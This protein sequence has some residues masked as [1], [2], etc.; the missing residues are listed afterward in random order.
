[1]DM[2][3]CSTVNIRFI[4]RH[5]AF[6][7]ELVWTPNLFRSASPG[8]QIS[9]GAPAW[10]SAFAC[11]GVEKVGNLDV[12]VPQGARSRVDAVQRVDLRSELFAQHVERL[13][14]AD[15]VLTQPRRETYKGLL[16]PIIA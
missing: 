15:A 1:M 10:Q 7:P 8:P 13:I 14:S 3:K 9:R 12:S 16:A 2:P 4:H 11:V 5:D 6:P